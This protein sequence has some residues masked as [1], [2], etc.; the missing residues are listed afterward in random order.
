VL[1]HP[2]LLLLQV[3]NIL[4]VLNVLQALIDK[5]GII[6]ELERDGGAELSTH[7]GYI[8]NQSNVLRMLGYFSLVGQLRVS[9]VPSKYH[10]TIYTPAVR[11][12]EA[13][14]THSTSNFSAY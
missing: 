12:D 3:W 13:L 11:K 7:E 5:S 2:L 10:G 14:H 6:A 8:P 9:Y 1:L 4:D